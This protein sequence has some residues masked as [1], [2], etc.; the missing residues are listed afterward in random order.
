MRSAPP[1]TD[2]DL[3][4]AGAGRGLCR[5]QLL[6]QHLRGDGQRRPLLVRQLL[7]RCRRPFRIYGGC[8]VY[9]AADRPRL[10]GCIGW[11]LDFFACRSGR[12]LVPFSGGWQRRNVVCRSITGR[13][14]S[15]AGIGSAGAAEVDEPL[16]GAGCLG[17]LA[18]LLYCLRLCWLGEHD[19]AAAPVL[20]PLRMQAEQQ[21]VA[22]WP[23]Q[24]STLLCRA[25]PRA[26]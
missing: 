16:A 19:E 23:A 13:H 2:L 5:R 22:P 3:R 10:A 7:L 21:L 8:K 18:L 1:T 15:A 9:C 24:D 25:R 6:C 14:R 20:Q 26:G 4:A 17:R 12:A 11:G